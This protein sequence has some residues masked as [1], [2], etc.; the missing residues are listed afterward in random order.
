MCDNSSIE[1]E[2]LTGRIYLPDTRWTLWWPIWTTSYKM[3]VRIIKRSWSKLEHYSQ[4]P[5]K[6]KLSVEVKVHQD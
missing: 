1:R 5:M 2:I 4:K 3:E 6:Y